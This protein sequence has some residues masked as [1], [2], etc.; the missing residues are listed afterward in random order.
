MEAL[1]KEIGVPFVSSLLQGLL[2]NAMN[3]G[4]NRIS[5]QAMQQQMKIATALANMAL[6][7]GEVDLPFRN[8]VFGALRQRSQ[9]QFPRILPDM[10][11]PAF[12]LDRRTMAPPASAFR[13][14]TG[15]LG[16]PGPTISPL[17]QALMAQR[18]G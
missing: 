7:Q 18:G 13:Q 15:P 10:N 3:G 8:D 1:L 12:Q 6:K 2:G 16:H 14:R 4:N 5:R 17:A 9:Q 11:R